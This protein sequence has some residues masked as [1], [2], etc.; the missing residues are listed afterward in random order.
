MIGIVSLEDDVEQWAIPLIREIHEHEP[1]ARVVLEVVKPGEGSYAASMNTL[2]SMWL[3]E[4]DDDYFIPMNADV[5]CR[6]PFLENVATVP[7][8]ML[9]GAT[10]NERDGLSWIDGWIYIIPR[11]VWN[12]V[13]EFDENF[14]IACFEDADYTWRAEAEGFDISKV[15]LPFVHY[16]ASP[17]MRVKDF[18]KIRKQ[19]Q[20]YLAEKW[21]LGDEWRYR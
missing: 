14:K 16:R 15:N 1:N 11:Q 13:G 10:I 19:N 12:T 18:W 3:S 21:N 4:F 17:R 6:A 7:Q 2:A 5:S 20:A 8:T 9:C